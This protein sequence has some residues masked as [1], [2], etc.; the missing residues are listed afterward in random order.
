MVSTTIEFKCKMCGAIF[1][2]YAENVAEGKAKL[3]CPNCGSTPPDEVRKKFISELKKFVKIK[4]EMSNSL[5]P[6]LDTFVLHSHYLDHTPE[7]SDEGNLI[8]RKFAHID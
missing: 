2:L 3:V 4:S 1:E 7:S 5:L 6:V 8:L